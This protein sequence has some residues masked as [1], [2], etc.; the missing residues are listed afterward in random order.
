MNDLSHNP[1]VLRN[2]SRRR[3]LQ[4]VA[5]TGGL[6]LAAQLPI[7]VALAYQDAQTAA[8]LAQDYAAILADL[9][10]VD[11]A[12]RL[13]GS[14]DGWHDTSGLPNARLRTPT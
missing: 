1:L 13:I 11:L 10:H 3:L 2:V 14:A 4:G 9:G 7:P 12:A 6:V 8:T 5:A